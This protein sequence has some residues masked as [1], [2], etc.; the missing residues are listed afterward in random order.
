ELHVGTFSEA[1]TFRSVVDHLPHLV[2]LGVTHVELM[3]VVEF[4]G[5]RGWGYDGVC[6]FAPHHT[7]GGPD[8]LKTLIDTCH[9]FGLGVIIDVVYNHLGPDGNYL[10]HFGPY[11][12]T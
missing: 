8:G 9:S 7:Y 5:N 4:P 1:G 11:F 2:E 12:T 6:L 10:P 3:P